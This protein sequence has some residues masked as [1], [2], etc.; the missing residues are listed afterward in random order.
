[1]EINF[2]GKKAL[3]TG[4]GKGKLNH[5]VTGMYLFRLTSEIMRLD[6]MVLRDA[7]IILLHRIA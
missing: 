4:A 2:C 5:F 1:M 7:H 6:I 3:V